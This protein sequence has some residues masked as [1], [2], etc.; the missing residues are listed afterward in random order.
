MLFGEAAMGILAV[1]NTLE[2]PSYSLT[3]WQ[4][5]HRIDSSSVL[6]A[7]FLKAGQKLADGCT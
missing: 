5:R 4:L 6:A 3:P 1:Y 2:I 7:E